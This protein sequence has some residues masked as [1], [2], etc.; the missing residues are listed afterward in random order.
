MS[1]LWDHMA[2]HVL[3]VTAFTPPPPPPLEK[4]LG[5]SVFLLLY[6]GIK[7]AVRHFAFLVIGWVSLLLH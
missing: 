5:R 1:V 2:K 4:I 3:A 7:P 6:G